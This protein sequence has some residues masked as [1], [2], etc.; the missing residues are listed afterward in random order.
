MRH[1]FLP[2]PVRALHAYDV[3]SRL[4]ENMGRD[5]ES[6]LRVRHY[7]TVRLGPGRAAVAK[8]P[9]LLPIRSAKRPHLEGHR[10]SWSDARS[11]P[12]C[13]LNGRR[14]LLRM[15]RI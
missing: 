14:R 3:I 13:R 8:G 15:L 4:L 2:Q 9:G 6:I 10:R 5:G 11:R 1:G 12:I 7:V